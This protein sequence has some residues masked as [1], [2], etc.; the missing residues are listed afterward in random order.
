MTFNNIIC[1]DSHIVLKD[2]N[3]NLFGAGNGERGA[4]GIL[5][6]HNNVYY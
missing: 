6:Q 5:P 2:E 1:G 4:L 3:N